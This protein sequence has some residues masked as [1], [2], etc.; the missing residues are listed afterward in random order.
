MDL[1]LPTARLPRTT[2]A[3]N[4]LMG[5]FPRAT[6]HLRVRMAAKMAPVLEKAIRRAPL[7]RIL[8]VKL[9]QRLQLQRPTIASGALLKFL[10]TRLPLILPLGFV[11][12]QTLPLTKPPL[13]L[14]L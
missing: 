8:E 1:L 5:L 14:R 3:M 12:L 2:V 7:R 4:R 6:Y 11:L 10:S 9:S 13:P